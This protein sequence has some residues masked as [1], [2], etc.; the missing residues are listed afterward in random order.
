MTT[1]ET[2]PLPDPTPPKRLLRTT[3]DRVLGGVAGG[4]GKHLNVDPV[5]FRILFVVLVFF[6]GAGFLAYLVAWIFVPAD[7]RAA[8]RTGRRAVLRTAGKVG[9]VVL[10]VLIAAGAGGA[11]A[12]TGG[13]TAVAIVVIVAGGLLVTGGLT[14]RIRWLIAPALALALSASVVAAADVDARGGS[15]ERIYKP[16][17]ADQVRSS[18]RLGVGHLVVDLRDTKLAPGDHPIALHLGVGGAEVLVPDDVCVST[19]AH[20]GIGG[21]QVFDRDSGGVDVDWEDGRSA[22]AGVARVIVDADIGIG[23]LRIQPGTHGRYVGNGACA[24][25]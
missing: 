2:T 18:Y 24:R 20:F 3:G 22:P 14:G 10:A 16:A 9:L 8:D 13:G 15:G 4:L 6:G 12:A 19:T 11:W 5:I 17:S 23:G 21:S 1:Q 25:D 7:D